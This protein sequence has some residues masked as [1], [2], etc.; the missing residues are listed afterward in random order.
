MN[1][2]DETKGFITLANGARYQVLDAN[3]E[4]DPAATEV[5]IASLPPQ[6]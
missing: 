4:F 5:L 1:E 6:G 2:I 3:G